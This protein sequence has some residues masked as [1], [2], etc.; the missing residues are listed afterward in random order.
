MSFLGSLTNL[1]GCDQ[2]FTEGI[3]EMRSAQ[4]GLRVESLRCPTTE[5]YFLRAYGASLTAPEKGVAGEK[6]NQNGNSSAS[7][8]MEH[9]AG[10]GLK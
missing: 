1:P 4:R 5:S 7:N 8:A 10:G 9:L 2:G 3:G 6:P